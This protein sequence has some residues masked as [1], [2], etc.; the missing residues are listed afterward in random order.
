VRLL[1][2]AMVCFS[3]AMDDGQFLRADVATD[4]SERKMPSIQFSSGL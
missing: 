3:W 2:L 4:A 1:V